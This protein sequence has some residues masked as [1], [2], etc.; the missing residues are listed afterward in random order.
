[1]K[2]DRVP[3][4]V[5]FIFWMIG[6]VVFS[7]FIPIANISGKWLD[8]TQAILLGTMVSVA[9]VTAETFFY[10]TKLSEKD[11]LKFALWDTLH[12]FD[13]KALYYS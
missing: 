2:R 4:W 11:D 13:N 1:M 3:F 7:A 8:A 12:N 10:L 6:N 5:E 9:L